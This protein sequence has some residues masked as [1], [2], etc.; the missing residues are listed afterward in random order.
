[1]TNI[2]VSLFLSALTL[3]L[4]FF[5]STSSLYFSSFSHIP[6]M[7]YLLVTLVHALNYQKKWIQRA[8]SNVKSNKSLPQ[9]RNKFG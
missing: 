6:S 5:L 9:G 7:P 1:M 4:T 2:H 8:L 3:T